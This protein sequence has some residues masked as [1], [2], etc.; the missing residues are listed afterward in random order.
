MLL[1]DWYK[2]MSKRRRNQN[3][4]R[5]VRPFLEDFARTQNLIL[6]TN[7]LTGT[8]AF[9]YRHPKGGHGKIWVTNRHKNNPRIDAFWAY[10]DYD[11][12]SYRVI[13][14]TKELNSLEQESLR[15]VLVQVLRELLSWNMQDTT[16]HKIR[17]WNWKEIYTRQEFDHLYDEYPVPSL[18]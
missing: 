16:V 1:V 15:G 18:D 5:T 6:T 11:T 9:I 3:F 13:E 4:V 17:R 14:L 2:S 10:D 7:E 12:C 8:I